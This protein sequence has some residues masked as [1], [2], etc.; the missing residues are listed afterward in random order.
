MEERER[1]QR[2]HRLA[3]QIH[4]AL[5]LS[6]LL[7]FLVSYFFSQTSGISVAS[8]QEHGLWRQGIYGL[9]FVMGI[10]V[11]LLRRWLLGLRRLARVMQQQGVEGA[12]E[13]LVKATLLLGSL[14]E[15][16]ALL[17]FGLS[18]RTRVFEDMWRV[19]GI[20]AILLLYTY[21][22]RSAWS[23][24]LERARQA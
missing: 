16:V 2:R 3:S 17:G 4:A 9:A 10:G 13:H 22:W 8:A 20:G 5:L 11:I 14:S 6:A 21:P 1:L 23:R 12:I 7:Y 15:C 24:A 19:G 18:L